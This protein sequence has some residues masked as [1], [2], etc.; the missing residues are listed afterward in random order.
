MRID[1]EC[2][3]R[4]RLDELK[5]ILEEVLDLGPE[6]TAATLERICA[7]DSE[8]RAQVEALLAADR[9]SRNFLTRPPM[10]W[11]RGITGS[12]LRRR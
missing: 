6:E 4:E 9:G 7:D 8:L 10:E 5:R 2:L 3:S 12:R 1:L 11:I